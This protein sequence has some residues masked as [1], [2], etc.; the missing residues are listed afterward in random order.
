[1][2]TDRLDRIEALLERTIET[3]AA[4]KRQAAAE[5]EADKQQAAAE[6][7]ASRR[8]MA[9]LRSGLA[10]LRSTVTALVQVVEVHQHNFE[11]IVNEIRGLRTESQRIL[12]YLFGQ[13]QNGE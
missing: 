3:I 4:D 9:E 11:V 7:Q 10:E 13:Q 2:S 1:M 6:H 8:E 5:R 12:E